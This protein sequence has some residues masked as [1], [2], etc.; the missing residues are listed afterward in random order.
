MESHIINTMESYFSLR[1]RPESALTGSLSNQHS[2][3][4]LVMYVSKPRLFCKF[5]TD[6]VAAGFSRETFHGVSSHE[7]GAK[8]RN[9]DVTSS[10]SPI[11]S[12]ARTPCDFHL[13]SRKRTIPERRRLGLAR[14]RRRGFCARDWTVHQARLVRGRSSSVIS[15]GSFTVCGRRCDSFTPETRFF[16]TQ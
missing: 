6:D 2:P 1:L 13:L 8:S 12:L 16:K 14:V 5:F 9:D 10:F 7:A 15:F 3:L 11:A 4:T